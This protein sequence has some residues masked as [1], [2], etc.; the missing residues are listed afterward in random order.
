VEPLNQE[1]NNS[2]S[3]SPLDRVIWDTS[4]SKA[5]LSEVGRLNYNKV[6]IVCSSSLKKNTDEIEKV[7]NV[8]GSKLV[9]VFSKCLEHSPIDNVIECAQEVRSMNPDIILTIGGGTPIDTVKVVQ[10]CHSLNINSEEELKKIANKF[11]NKNS[12][13]RQI[14]IPTTLSGGEYSNMGGALDTKKQLKE[15]Y[16][17]KDLCPKVVILDPEITLHT[18]DWLWLS[19]AIR[20]VDHAIEGL[21][22][23]STNPLIYPMALHSLGEFAASLRGTFKDR[24]DLE[25]RSRAQKAVWM[26]AKNLGNVSMGA[27]HG[28]GYLLGSICSIP[29]GYTSCVLLPAVLKWNESENLE[30][31]DLISKALGKP[32]LSASQ[33]VAELISDLELPKN[34]GEVGVLEEHWQKIAEYGLK[35]PTVLS[36]P[37]PI[38]SEQ[39]IL[40]ILELASY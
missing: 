9:G 8:L 21:C 4:S 17:G 30:K 7:S 25:S 22:S 39:D 29:H 15:R 20:S 37:K 11:Q 33:A 3:Y 19:T 31:Q 38:K 27:S 18:P 24:N 14:A 16:L 26:I 34:L 32:D 6:F 35:H 23:S 1:I 2:Y 28:L 13:I 12:K 10:L 36:N 5:I 40:E